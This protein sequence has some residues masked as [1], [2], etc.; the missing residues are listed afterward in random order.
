MKTLAIA[1]VVAAVY[2][3]VGVLI[4]EPVQNFGLIGQVARMR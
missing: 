1:I 2:A 3:A 4:V